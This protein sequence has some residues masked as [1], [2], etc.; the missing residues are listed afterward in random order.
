MAGYFVSFFVE[1]NIIKVKTCIKNH[2][3]RK[4]TTISTK[5][6]L[7]MYCVHCIIREYLHIHAIEVQ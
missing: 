5:V 7:T 2:I 6:T 4:K 1:K 3:L